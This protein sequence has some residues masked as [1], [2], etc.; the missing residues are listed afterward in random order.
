[1][2]ARGG[3]RTVERT[4]AVSRPAA[5]AGPVAAP[6]TQPEGD[7]A[8]FET[9]ILGLLP[10]L[11]ATAV[12]LAKNRADAEDLVAEAVAKAWEHLVSL[13]DRSRFRGWVMRILTNTFVSRCRAARAA[14]D[15]TSLDEGAE[16]DERFSLFERLHQPFLLW[17][18][19]PEQE[20]L[21]KLLRQDLEAAIDAL[22]E[23]FRVVVVL[24]DVQGLSY[25]EIA[26]TL[27]LPIGTVRSRLARARSRLQRALW[28]HG[29]DRGL[30][31][32]G[33]GGS[34]SRVEAR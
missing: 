2:S 19:N 29:A 14:P 3:G 31:E 6:G 30:G 12:R 7:P 20:F 32:P 9:E 4:G 5:K 17:W 11:L 28:E 13:K 22:P 23:A 10:E 33:R 21:N 16:D 18:G 34:D 24:A 26:N 8:W 15:F 27:E 25:D 1:M